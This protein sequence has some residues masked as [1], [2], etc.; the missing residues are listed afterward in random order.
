[1]PYSGSARST[2]QPHLGVEAGGVDVVDEQVD[3]VEAFER[4]GGGLGMTEL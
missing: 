2:V 3:M 1:M 4:E